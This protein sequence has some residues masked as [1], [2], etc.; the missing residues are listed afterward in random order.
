MKTSLTAGLTKEEKSE[1]SAN[2]INAL[3]LR[4]RVIEMLEKEIES[5]NTNMRDEDH[6]SSPNW[7]LIQADRIAQIKAKKKL[8]SLFEK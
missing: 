1:L 6:F 8:I 4:K 3:P 2:F 5:L 7:A